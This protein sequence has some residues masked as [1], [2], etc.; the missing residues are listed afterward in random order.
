LESFGGWRWVMAYST[1]K[2]PK[3]LK[4]KGLFGGQRITL[5]L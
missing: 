2:S 1:K 3:C 4:H 5:D